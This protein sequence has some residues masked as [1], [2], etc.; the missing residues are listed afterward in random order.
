MI[1]KMN[2]MS[3]CRLIIFTIWRN[4]W[5]IIIFSMENTLKGTSINL[6]QQTT[7]QYRQTST[8]KLSNISNNINK[9]LSNIDKYQ[10]LLFI[11]GYVPK[12]WKFRHHLQGSF[13]ATGRPQKWGRSK[14]IKMR[15]KII[16]K[17]SQI[18]TKSAGYCGWWCLNMPEWFSN[19]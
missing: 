18:L 1:N 17:F 13:T 9:N 6:Y 8:K 7:K 5:Y 2:M 16:N 4:I 15:S 10:P 3:L 14:L 19:A 11:T 12:P